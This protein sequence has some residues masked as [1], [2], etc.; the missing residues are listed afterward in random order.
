M[1][2]S[3][4]VAGALHGPGVPPGPRHPHGPGKRGRQRRVLPHRIPRLLA[5]RRHGKTGTAMLTCHACHALTLFSESRTATQR[6]EP[7]ETMSTP[8]QSTGAFYRKKGIHIF[9]NYGWFVLEKATCFFAISQHIRYTARNPSIIYR[10]DGHMLMCT[11]TSLKPVVFA[12]SLVSPPPCSVVTIIV[13][14]F[15]SF[16]SPQPVFPLFFSFCFFFPFFHLPLPVFSR[17][18]LFSFVFRFS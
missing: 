8:Q 17:F 6:N 7:F 10:R 4:S 2:F 3:L 9:V 11:S 1:L 12:I 18:L 14:T 16:P 5:A 15:L 13:H